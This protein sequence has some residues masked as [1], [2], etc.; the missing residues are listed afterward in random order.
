MYNFSVEFFLNFMFDGYLCLNTNRKR[1]L[2]L[3]KLLFVY[4]STFLNLKIARGKCILQ[5]AT[6]SN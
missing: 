2:Y 4:Q 6:Q 3:F 5:E 1:D